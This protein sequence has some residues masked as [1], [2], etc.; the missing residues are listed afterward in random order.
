MPTPIDILAFSPHPDDAELGCGG[1]LILAADQ[2]LR[3]AIADLSAGEMGSG[4]S[5]AIREAERTEAAGHLGLVERWLVG[6][7][8]SRIGQ[9]P[10]HR[11]PLIAL[12]RHARPRVVLAPYW[13][14]RHPDHE[15]AA[16]LVREACFLAGVG[17]VGSGAPHRPEHLFHYMLHSPFDPSFVVDVSAVWERRQAALLAYRSQF[18][19]GATAIGRPDFLRAMEARAIWYGAQIGAAYG[20]P[21]RLRGPLGLPALPLPPARGPLPPYRPF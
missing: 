5:R 1:S 12:I 2:G 3:V 11:D 4:G 9:A 6:L 20:E 21:F 17:K 16:R 19:G 13:R 8:D 10:G 7:P 14:D 15:A 18:E